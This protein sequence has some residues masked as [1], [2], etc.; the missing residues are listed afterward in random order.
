M[1]LRAII[2]ILF[3]FAW[4]LLSSFTIDINN[5]TK[6]DKSKI[7]FDTIPYMVNDTYFIQAYDEIV[8]MLDGK[9]SLNIKRAQ[10]LMEWA[11][12]EGDLDYNKFCSHIDSVVLDLSAFIRLNGIQTYKTA[13]NFALFEYFTKPSPLNGN[14][15][16]KYDFNDFTGKEDYRQVFVSKVMQ[17]HTGQCTSLPM[18]YKILSDE[19]GAESF[20]A[21]A[22]NHMYIKHIAENGKWVNIELTNGHFATDAWMIS[23]MD[24]SAEAIKNRVY[25]DAL[26]DKQTICTILTSLSIAYQRKYGYDYFSLACVDKALEYYPQYIPA[27]AIKFNVH[28]FLGLQYVEKFGQTYS[29][30]I[31]KNH[32]DFKDTQLLIENLGYRELSP[33]NYESW[34]NSMDEELAKQAQE[35]Q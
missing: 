15:S 22:P 1:K 25:L 33:E 5:I 20:I 9:D 35:Q 16:F 21:T 4:T 32:K 3:F 11:Y 29:E 34:L 10:F 28:Q 18:Y 23:S 19:L 27:L 7:S 17:T 13:G 30:F 26:D 31:A 24:I 2:Y 8:R 6:V 14:K 12:T